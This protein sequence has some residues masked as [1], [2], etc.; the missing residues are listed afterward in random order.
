MSQLSEQEQSTLLLQT[1]QL[2]S[3]L[4]TLE[5]QAWDMSKETNRQE[6]R[7]ENLWVVSNLTAQ[8]LISRHN[9]ILAQLQMQINHLQN[10]KLQ[11]QLLFQ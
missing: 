1:Q 7:L 3:A 9:Q 6:S 5:D 10:L 4:D 8:E 2:Q 11:Y